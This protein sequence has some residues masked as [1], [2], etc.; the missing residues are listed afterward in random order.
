MKFKLEIRKSP[1]KKNI[2]VLV[3]LVDTYTIFNIQIINK[4]EIS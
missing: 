4:V 1:N 2:I 3:D